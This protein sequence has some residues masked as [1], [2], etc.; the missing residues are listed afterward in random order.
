MKE[1]K[2]KSLCVYYLKKKQL[3]SIHE[4]DLNNNL[5]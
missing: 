3:K 4:F 2:Q 1:K 5:Y